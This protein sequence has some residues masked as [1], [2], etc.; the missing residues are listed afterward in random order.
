MDINATITTGFTIGITGITI[1][2]GYAQ[3]KE[4][5]AT[6]NILYMSKR[7][8]IKHRELVLEEFEKIA[9]KI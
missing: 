3:M 8:Y 1:K 4:M 5:F 2:I 6:A 7:K 9:M